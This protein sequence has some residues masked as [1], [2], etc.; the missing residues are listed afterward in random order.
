MITLMNV[1]PSTIQLV[2]SNQID[3]RALEYVNEET[4]VWFLRAS[5]LHDSIQNINN[6]KVNFF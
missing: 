6:Q 1:P 3:L 5:N 4:L 2:L